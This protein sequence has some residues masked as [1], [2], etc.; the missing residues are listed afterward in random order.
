MKLLDYLKPMESLPNRFSNLAFW[1]SLRI[2]KD[3]IV[4]AFTYV[5]SWGNDI[6]IEQRSQNVSITEHGQKITALVAEQDT[7]NGGIANN[8]ADIDSL[9]A[10][11]VDLQK[12]V[13]NGNKD[14]FITDTYLVTYT[15]E[16]LKDFWYRLSPTAYDVELKS[17]PHHVSVDSYVL[18]YNEDKTKTFTDTV[19]IPSRLIIDS[20]SGKTVVKLSAFD[21]SLPYE[22]ATQT[23]SVYIYYTVH[24]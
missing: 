10:D 5:N 24:R 21:L 6:E 18:R 22:I 15:V 11:F 17:V 23:V 8:R 4:D 14:D 7:Q 16:K 2:L 9:S 12:L 19:E 13:F 3:K 1:R 20:G